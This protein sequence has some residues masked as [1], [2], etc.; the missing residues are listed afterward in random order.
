MLHA[1]MIA[2]H[3]FALLFSA[4]V[5][6]VCTYYFIF[7]KLQSQV[8]LLLPSDNEFHGVSNEY[9]FLRCSFHALFWCQTVYL[10]YVIVQQC[11]SDIIFVDWECPRRGNRRNKNTSNNTDG[12]THTTTTARRWGGT[13]VD[14]ANTHG[15]ALRS[16]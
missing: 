2:C 10:V 12:T 5:F 1:V 11:Q 13:Q 8:F 6:L 15:A 9:F 4:F 7:F 16:H 3:T 14:G